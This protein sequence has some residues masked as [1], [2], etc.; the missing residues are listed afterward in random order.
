MPQKVTYSQLPSTIVYY[1]P[2]KHA[3]LGLL[4]KLIRNILMILGL[5]LVGGVLFL[6]FQGQQ[7]AHSFN[8]EFIGFF[9]KFVEQVLKKDVASAMVIK[10]PLEKG[11]T[12]KQAID[13]MKKRAAQ[14][15][16][17]LIA[18]YPLH[19]EIKALTGKPSRFVEI[20]EFCD[21]TR[22]AALLEHNP[23]FAAYL[24]CRI[25]VYEDKSGKIWFATLNLELLLHGTQGIDPKVKGQALENQESLLKIMGAGAHGVL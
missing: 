5:L 19:K 6:Y 23:D 13:A 18:T 11:V 3:L 2:K 17:K 8:D 9:G 1:K 14:L 7:L 24:P 16:I 22:V 4:F 20:F 10:T 21:A 15:K 12:R 25:A